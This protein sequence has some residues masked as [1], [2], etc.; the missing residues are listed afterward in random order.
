[1]MKNNNLERERVILAA[2][3]GTNAGWLTSD[4]VEALRGGHG[5]LNIPVIAVCHPR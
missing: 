2:V 3:T 1:M 4:W 5:M